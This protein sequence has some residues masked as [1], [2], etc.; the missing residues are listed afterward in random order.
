MRTAKSLLDTRADIILASLTSHRFSWTNRTKRGEGLN[1]Y[2]TTKER[3]RTDG[4]ILVQVRTGDLCVREWFDIIL[5][6]AIDM[7]LCMSFN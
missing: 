7:L 3:L 5:S 4:L 1:L 2:T 6:L